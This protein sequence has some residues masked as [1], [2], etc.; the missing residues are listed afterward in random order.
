[1]TSVFTPS[2][3]IVPHKPDLRQRRDS[4]IL[5]ARQS[6]TQRAGCQVSLHHIFVY[7]YLLD[8]RRWFLVHLA[9]YPE[10]LIQ[11]RSYLQINKL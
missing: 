6:V 1:M 4:A 11:A 10:R 8:S 3:S 5:P 9:A 2:T 7:V